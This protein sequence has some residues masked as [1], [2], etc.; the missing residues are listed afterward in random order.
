[1]R[2]IFGNFLMLF[3]EILQ[4]EGGGVPL[5]PSMG[6]IELVFVFVSLLIAFCDEDKE[7]WMHGR[8]NRNLFV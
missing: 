1:M 5:D 8:S 3:K 7:I 6:K 4:R 2:N